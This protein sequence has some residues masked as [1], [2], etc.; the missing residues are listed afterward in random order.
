MGAM[1]GDGNESVCGEGRGDIRDDVAGYLE[2]LARQ[3][4][5]RGVR[6]ASHAAE[7]VR[8][9]ERF[10]QAIRQEVTERLEVAIEKL[11]QE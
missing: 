9:P 3:I 11:L 4:R 7:R 2:E 5:V 10:V 6:Y 1:R 8:L